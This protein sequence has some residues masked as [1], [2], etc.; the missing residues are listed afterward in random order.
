MSILS[1]LEESNI[2]NESFTDMCRF[3][4][5][6]NGP[7]KIDMFEEK[8]GN[9]LFKVRSILPLNVRHSYSFCFQLKIS[10]I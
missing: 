9:I 10:L 3:C 1:V 8:D 5:I 2:T 6:K 7:P 4:A